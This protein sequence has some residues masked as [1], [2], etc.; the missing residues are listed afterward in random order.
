MQINGTTIN[1]TAHTP[2]LQ[3]YNVL[4][5]IVRPVKIS[6]STGI[7]ESTVVL[8]AN[9]MCAIGWKT[10]SEK[11]MFNKVSYFLDAIMICRVFGTAVK[12]SDR[13]VHQGNVFEI[14][15]VMDISNLGRRWKIALRRIV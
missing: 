14:V 3:I 8:A 1:I 7:E 13:V 15:D 10:G 12:V 6:T 4:V 9:L 2:R 11:I 5:D